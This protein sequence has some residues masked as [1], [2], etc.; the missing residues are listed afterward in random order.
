MQ[1]KRYSIVPFKQTRVMKKVL[2]L[3]AAALSLLGVASVDAQVQVPAESTDTTS[4]EIPFDGWDDIEVLAPEEALLP[5]DP[6]SSVG[7]TP[8]QVE[9]A[10]EYAAK[11]SAGQT[12]WAADLAKAAADGTDPTSSK[13]PFDGGDEDTEVPVPETVPP[14]DSIAAAGL[15]AEQAE[16]LQ[17]AKI[18]AAEEQAALT[19]EQQAQL[20]A[21]Q[22]EQEAQAEAYR[23]YKV[24]SLITA[25]LL[26]AEEAIASGLITEAELAEAFSADLRGNG[27]GD[28]DKMTVGAVLDNA[29]RLYG[30]RGAI[31]AE[32]AAPTAVSVYNTAG[33][34][35]RT[36]AV[37][38]TADFALPSGVYLVRAGNQTY[39]VAV[40]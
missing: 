29:G 35:L 6:L 5:T 2:F 17:A 3:S 38:G 30:T 21:E 39:K 28:G 18:K 22:A 1:D 10:K 32:F 26:T 4:S 19:A 33:V 12:Q 20:E 7:M 36:A 14:T 13:V 34:R 25:G 37:K 16:A 31:R 24:V 15:T 23:K 8:A 40:R 9:A 27:G 11:M